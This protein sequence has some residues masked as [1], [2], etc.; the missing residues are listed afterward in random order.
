MVRILGRLDSDRMISWSAFAT[1][2]FKPVAARPTDVMN[3][4]LVV[5]INLDPLSG[6]LANYSE[7]LSTGARCRKRLLAMLNMG[8]Y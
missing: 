1:L 4:R 2:L 8:E 5:L 7:M 3:C 6:R